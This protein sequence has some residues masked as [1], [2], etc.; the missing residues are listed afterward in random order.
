MTTFRSKLADTVGYALIVI[1]FVGFFVCWGI[2]WDAQGRV[3]GR[4]EFE[5]PT[6][7]RSAPIEL[8]GATFYVEPDYAHRYRFADNFGLL[9]W[10]V[11]AA[12]GVI[13]N[14]AKI[15]EWWRRRK[16]NK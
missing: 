11:T 5:R 1:G 2:G 16:V 10:S 6:P 15:A 13:Q 9:F 8:K 12:G 3:L 4:S 14:R 7:Q